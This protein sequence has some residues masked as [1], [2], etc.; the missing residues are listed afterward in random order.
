M[1]TT[2]QEIIEAA[3]KGL[4]GRGPRCIPMN[5]W[6]TLCLIPN[7]LD[8][9]RPSGISSSKHRSQEVKPSQAVATRSMYV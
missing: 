8:P 2:N 5:W 9:H 7:K 4:D 6:G 1:A 3:R